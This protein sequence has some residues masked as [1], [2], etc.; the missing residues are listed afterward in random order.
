[1][2]A[3]PAAT[4]VTSPV[5]ASTVATDVLPLA[6]VPPEIAS[7]SSPVAPVQILS[8]PDIGGGAALTAIFEVTE[9]PAGNIVYVQVKMP[10]ALPV[11]VPVAGLIVATNDGVPLHRPPGV[12]SD[13]VTAAPTHKPAGPAMGAGGGSTVI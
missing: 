1:M 5:T 8:V 11:I 12:A 3:V 9:Q 10:A 13:I 6:H 4:P 2:A 7:L